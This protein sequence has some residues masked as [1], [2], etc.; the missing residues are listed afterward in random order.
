MNRYLVTLGLVT[1]GALV[2]IWPLGALGSILVWL[3]FY[4]VVMVSGIVGGFACGMLATGLACGVA[5]WLGPYL[6]GGPFI[7][8]TADWIGLAVFIV[9]GTMMSGVAEAMLRASARAR[10]AQQQAEQ[11]NRAKSA[12]L[13]NMS[14]ELRTPLNSILGFSRI[15]RSGLASPQTRAEDLDVIIRSGEHLLQLINNVLDMSKIEAGRV[16]LEPVDTDLHRL[17]NEIHTEMAVQAAQQRQNLRLEMAADLPRQ[18]RLDAGKL[19]QVLINLLGNAIKFTPPAGDVML[20]AGAA[21]AP[22]A[23]PAQGPGTA[24]LHIRFAVTDTGPGIA[25]AD[26][27]RLFKPFVQLLNQPAA[28]VQGTGLGLAISSQFVEMMQ[29]HLAVRSAPGAGAEFSFTI[30]VAPSKQPADATRPL[31]AVT[32]LAAG[33]RRYK[34]L[35]VEDHEHNRRLLQR[36]LEPLGFELREAENGQA[37]IELWQAWQPDLIFMDIRMPVMDGMEAT[38]RIRASGNTA[39][40]RVPIVALTAHALEEERMDILACGCNSVVRKPYR[41]SEIFDALREQLG[42]RYEYAE[43]DA[44]AVAPQ[45][46]PLDLQRLAALPEPLLRQLLRAVELLE[47]ELCLKVAGQISDLDP[48]LGRELRRWIDAAQYRPLLDALDQILSKT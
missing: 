14:H 13:A 33:Q 24:A 47:P 37:A 20:R 25:E 8:S 32:G 18:L 35:N 2:R 6:V 26:Q 3:T 44:A 5:L 27:Q 21:P 48:E 10:Q 45:H 30:P 17:L 15:L 12:F 36:L 7:T 11:A 1:L 19:R 42:L 40:A 43:V 41:D 46:A 16:E 29:G 9:N 39:A 23:A 38:R 4:P 34:L 22:A 31:T 28:G